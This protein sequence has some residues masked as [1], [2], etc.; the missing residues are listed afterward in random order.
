MYGRVIAFGIHPERVASAADHLV[1]SVV[2]PADQPGSRESWGLLGRSAGTIVLISAW[3]SPL[4]LAR[5]EGQETTRPL[6]G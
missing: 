6:L 1:H 2:P 4:E 5:T 3:D